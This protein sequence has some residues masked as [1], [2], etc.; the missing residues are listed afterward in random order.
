MSKER[1]DHGPATQGLTETRQAPAVDLVRDVMGGTS[2][3]RRKS[4]TYLPPFP[5]EDP[6]VYSAR[7]G[8]SVVFN[9][10]KRTVEAMTGMVMRKPLTLSDELP[11]E[12]IEHAENIDL[13]GRNIDQ[14]AKDHFWDAE[15][16][17]HALILVDMDP[18]VDAD[19]RAD[20]LESG[21]RP[22]W[23][24][25]PKG[26]IVGHR[27]AK[28][29]GRTVLA[30]LRYRERTTERVGEFT[31]QQVD[32]VRHYF[33][34]DAA[35]DGEGRRPAVMFQLWTLDPEIEWPGE[36][37]NWSAEPAREMKGI[38]EIPIAVTYT[39][40][41]GFMESDPPFVDLAF[42]NVRHFQTDSD[43]QNLARTA[44]VQTLVVT[45]ESAENMK[46]TRFGPGNGMVIESPDA[47]AKWIGADGSSFEVFLDDLGRIEQRMAIMGL[48][49]LHSETRQA[50][51][52]TSKRID[53]SEQD[54]QLGS[55]AQSLQ[56]ALNNAK[57]FHL[58]WLDTNDVGDIAVNMD[59]VD[60]P[61]DAQT[62]RVLFDLWL[63]RGIPLVTLLKAAQRGEL[64]PDGLDVDETMAELANESTFRLDAET[65]RIF[66]AEDGGAEE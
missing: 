28:I 9:A 47:D 8:R 33:I 63:E 27:A 32:R 24:H 57:R 1:T 56:M 22:Y 41:T 37:K 21:Q 52:A 40:R 15:A 29:A 20:E 35:Q 26:S 6:G 55:A 36:P 30:S 51:T 12:F 60:E 25:I 19:S 3:L 54:S 46:G 43:N 14:F 44:K 10:T 23:V 39:G 65:A 13:S 2:V 34:G 50:E 5:D 45:G 53:K 61:L 7:V 62:F 18:P 48:S 16:D 38:G 66:G 11:S 59:F 4:A 42:E 31:E 58:A 64:L 17:G 49:S